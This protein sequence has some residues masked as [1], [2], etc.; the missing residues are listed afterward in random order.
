[1]LNPSLLPKI[2]FNKRL[3][4]RKPLKV[5]L[6]ERDSLILRVP[7]KLLI[8][9]SSGKGKTTLACLFFAQ[10]KAGLFLDPKG[11]A[12]YNFRELGEGSFDYLNLKQFKINVADLSESVI[13]V[14]NLKKMFSFKKKIFLIITPKPVLW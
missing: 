12:G 5:L 4:E 8:T 13:N 7:I 9:G 3:L 6:N 2:D 1:M 10:F 11:H 14:L